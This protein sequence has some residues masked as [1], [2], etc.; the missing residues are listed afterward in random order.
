MCIIVDLKAFPCTS[1]QGHLFSWL[2]SWTRF[3]Q[4]SII[5]KN[6]SLTWLVLYNQ[7]ACLAYCKL[8]SPPSRLYLASSCGSYLL[9]PCGPPY[10]P[11]QQ[12]SATVPPSALT[13][14]VVNLF[15]G[16]AHHSEVFIHAV[17]D[18]T[19]VGNFFLWSFKYRVFNRTN[20]GWQELCR[21]KWI[22]HLQDC[23][24]M[25]VCVALVLCGTVLTAWLEAAGETV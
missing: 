13:R 10:K 4:K 19:K 24:S 14:P 15:L 25:K 18:Q 1:I 22:C 6:V 23:G 7:Q 2:C 5:L 3:H 12:E 17:S 9:P 8:I 16:V 21:L 20:T 11:A